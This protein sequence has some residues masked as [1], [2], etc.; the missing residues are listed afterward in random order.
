MTVTGKRIT[1]RMPNGD[2]THS[3]PRHVQIPEELQG[4]Y[5][6]PDLKSYHSDYQGLLDQLRAWIAA[7]YRQE[8]RRSNP[9]QV[10]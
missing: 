5:L 10:R 6:V 9:E 3:T 4:V 7:G 1:V 2:R 8:A